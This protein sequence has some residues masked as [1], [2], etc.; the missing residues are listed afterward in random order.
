[1][2][3]LTELL[4]LRHS[5]DIISI[6]FMIENSDI[7]D[8]IKSLIK[9]LKDNK[10]YWSIL[11]DKLAFL[12]REDSIE[13]KHICYKSSISGEMHDVF[14]NGIFI[15]PETSYDSFSVILRHCIAR[16]LR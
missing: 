5:F 4:L 3:E 15:S 8:E 16:C 9:A 2:L 7:D 6:E 13:I 14:V 11:K 12:Q 1:M 10:A